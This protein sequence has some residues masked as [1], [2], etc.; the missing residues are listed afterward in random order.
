MIERIL[1]SK[2]GAWQILTAT[3]CDGRLTILQ[4]RKHENG[5]I[6]MRTVQSD[7]IPGAVFPDSDMIEDLLAT[8][9]K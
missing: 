7:F 2:W 6:Q 9:V 5:K 4:A 3:P 8:I 1:K